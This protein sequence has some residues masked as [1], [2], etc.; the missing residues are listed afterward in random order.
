MHT[1]GR[2]ASLDILRGL[3][4]WFLLMVGPLLHCVLGMTGAS[5][6]AG[7]FIRYQMDHVVWS[8]FAAWD[9]IMP[10]F[11][12]MSGIT[13]PFSL[14]RYDRTLRPGKDFYLKLLRRFCLLFFLG[15]IVQ[16]NLLKFDIRQFHPFANTLQAIAVGYVVSALM[17]VH[18]GR[19]GRLIAT[20]AFFL[21]YLSAFVLTGMDLDP[22]SNVAMLIDKAVLGSHRDGVIWISAHEWV[23]DESYTYTWI[24]SSLNFVVTVMSGCFAGEILT[25]GG[26]TPERKKAVRLLAVG[27]V[28]VCLG[29]AMHPFF[30]IIKRIWSSSMTLYSAGVCY[31]LMAVCYYLIDVRECRWS[32]DWV[33]CFGMNSIVAYFVGEMLLSV[34]VPGIP[35]LASVAAKVVLLY[36]LMRIMYKYGCFLKV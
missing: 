35:L 36:V 20:L 15:W 14:S 23:F 16:G 5:G 8:G 26:R 17:F 28:L 10:L 25:E 9:I 3:D 13:I 33:K 29:L 11:L 21:A 12:F 30:P 4:L 34:H 27:A 1:E 18:L 19:R 6:A 31:I 22:Q 32:L 7:S 24:L 2:L